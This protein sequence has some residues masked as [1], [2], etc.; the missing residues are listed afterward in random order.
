[1]DGQ[2]L[3]K[4]MD[5]YSYWHDMVFNQNRWAYLLFIWIRWTLPRFR[6][7]QVMNLGW[8]KLLPLA[9]ANLVFYDNYLL[10]GLISRI[11]T[12]RKTMP[13]TVVLERNRFPF[14]NELIFPRLRLV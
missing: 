4:F 3:A 9:L 14:Q 5:W 1:M 7:D 10:P 11:L 2:S 8:T 12:Y 6:Y 13:K